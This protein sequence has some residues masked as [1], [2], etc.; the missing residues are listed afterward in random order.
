MFSG[1]DG[2]GGDVHGSGGGDGQRGDGHGGHGGDDHGSGG[3]DGHGELYVLDQL[4]M[5]ITYEI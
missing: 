2:H 3:G 4:N 5:H 1:S